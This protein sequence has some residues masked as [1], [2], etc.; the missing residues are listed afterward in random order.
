MLLESVAAAV[1]IAGANYGDYHSTRVGINQG[2]REVNWLYGRQG[3]RLD[4]KGVITLAEIIT[5]NQLISKGKKKEAFIFTAG[6]LV[7]NG[8]TIGMNQ[9]KINGK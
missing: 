9:R 7:V 5:V 4:M 6:I 2:L 3:E 8:I 1:L